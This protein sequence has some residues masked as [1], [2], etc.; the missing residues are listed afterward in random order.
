[1]RFDTSMKREFNDD[2]GSPIRNN[3]GGVMKRFLLSAAL[4]LSC[5]N[6]HAAELRV[7]SEFIVP[8][9]QTFVVVKEI[10]NYDTTLRYGEK[11]T[12]ST[13]A[14]LGKVLEIRADDVV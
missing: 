10:K 7:G 8:T 13:A 14:D 4:M 2:S 12:V 6:V 9:G 1:M 11:C 5:S 3:G